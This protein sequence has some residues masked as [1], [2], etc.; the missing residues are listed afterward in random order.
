VRA[1]ALCGAIL[2]ASAVVR[3]LPASGDFWL[4]EI[5][6]YFTVRDLPS[7]WSVFTS[8]HHSNNNHLNSLLL[9]GLGDRSSWVVYRV[10]SLLAGIGTVA[11]AARIGWERSR[12]EGI[13]AALLTGACFALIHFSSEARGYA[14]AV[15]FSLVAWRALVAHLAGRGR[16]AAALFAVSVVLGFL[17]HLTF[18]FFYAG[19]ILHSLL[20]LGRSPTDR[21]ALVLGLLQLHGLPVVAFAALYAVDLRH[22]MVGAGNPTDMATLAARTVGFSL[23]LPVIRALA[24][25][26]ALLAAALLGLSLRAMARDGDASWVAYLVTI[27]LAPLIVLVVLRPEVV[28]VRYF[29]IGITFTLLACAHLLAG[30]FA[31]GGFRRMLALLL[32]AGFVAGNGVYTAGFLERGRGGY[33]AALQFMARNTDGPYVVAS[34]DHDFRTRMTLHFYRSRLPADKRLVYRP[35]DE[36]PPGGTEWLILHQGARPELPPREVRDA[37]G[38][39]YHLAAEFDHGAIS[40]FYWAVYRNARSASP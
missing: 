24:L 33:L 37:A 26:Y 14:L 31:A 35:R 16:G 32:A 38:N 9:Y 6:T 17:S 25:P 18:L 21:R 2:A 28:A 36:R 30:L 15:F 39:T 40:G 23:G 3:A 11:L 13:F 1:L 27:V 7:A 12:T 29:L 34:G 8:I 10:P 4:D 5:W 19:A 20:V 22:L